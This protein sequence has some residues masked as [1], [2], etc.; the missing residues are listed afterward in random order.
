MEFQFL[1]QPITSNNGVFFFYKSYIIILY[2]ENKMWHF[3]ASDNFDDTLNKVYKLYVG[4]MPCTE[5]SLLICLKLVFLL[6][7]SM[8]CS[9]SWY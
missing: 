5:L 6:L 4:P 7:I 9:S 2:K 3:Y 1:V 8:L